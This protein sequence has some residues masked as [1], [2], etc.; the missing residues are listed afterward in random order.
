MTET[1]YAVVTGA[2]SGIGYA[3]T[4]ELAGKGYVVYAASRRTAPLEPLEQ[5]YGI[6]KVIGVKLDVSE[7][8]EIKAF[9]ERLEKSLPDGKL[10][11]LFNNAGQG[12]VVAATDVTNDQIEQCFKVNVFGSMN[13]TKELATLVINA[14]GVII[15][16]GSMAGVVATPFSSVYASTKAAIHQYAHVL[17][18]EMRPLG[19]KVINAI[20]GFVGTNISNS[21][22]S[23][24][25]DSLFATPEGIKLLEERRNMVKNNNPMPAN[26][27]AQKLVKDALSSADPVDVYRGTSASI[28]LWI[29]RLFPVK[30]IE[31]G[32]YKKFNTQPAYDAINKRKKD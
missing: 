6:E 1:K 15:F 4:D 22:N 16:T 10:H 14:K 27:Y 12:C 29:T 17:H 20:T 8:D 32:M 19:V 18:L 13:M 2:S 25:E 31:Y 9:R 21:K 28:F 3:I 11:L 24:P 5:K 23:I 30:L 26:I 7:P